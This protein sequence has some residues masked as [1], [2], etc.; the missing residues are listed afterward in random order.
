MDWIINSTFPRSASQ[1]L[2]NI[3]GRGAVEYHLIGAK[4]I[5]DYQ[6]VTIVK[7]TLEGP[8][9]VIKKIWKPWVQQNV[10]QQKMI[11][12]LDMRN[13]IDGAKASQEERRLLSKWSRV[14]WFSF[15]GIQT[16]N[17]LGLKYIVGIDT[18]EEEKLKLV[19]FQHGFVIFSMFIWNGPPLWKFDQLLSVSGKL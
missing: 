13:F 19:T 18:K 2:P 4:L 11:V 12:E 3:V 9:F 15:P 8:C 17:H 14:R 5:K 1:V 10:W 16:H 6:N 7:K